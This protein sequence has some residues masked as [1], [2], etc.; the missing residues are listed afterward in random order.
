MKG[1]RGRRQDDMSRLSDLCRDD[2]DVDREEAAL[3]A[4]DSVVA[5]PGMRSP[6]QRC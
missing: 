3:H 6:A 5:F 4:P 1:R 2:I